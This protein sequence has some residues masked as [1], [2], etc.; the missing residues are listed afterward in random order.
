MRGNV[1]TEVADAPKPIQRRRRRRALLTEDGESDYGAILDELTGDALKVWGKFL[2][3]P[4]KPGNRQ[5]VRSL[6][7]KERAANNVVRACIALG[8]QRLKRRQTDQL[9]KLL[10]E[11]KKHGRDT[12]LLEQASQVVAES[13]KGEED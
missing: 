1:L 3:A 6:T 9:Q 12:P 4:V 2:K 11:I 13:G 8:A 5:Y 7:I 10:D